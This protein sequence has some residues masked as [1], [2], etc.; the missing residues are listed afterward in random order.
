M[1]GNIR[2]LES[3]LQRNCV[4][5]FRLQYPHLIL[6]AIPNGGRRSAI[7]AAIMKGEGVMP[8]VADLF[9]MFPT[10]AH[11]GL[12]I[13]MKHRD[14]KQSEKQVRFEEQANRYG[15]GYAVARSFD[16]F[17]TVVKEFVRC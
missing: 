16:E 3:E 13:E 10:K 12:F 15:Y 1:T 5:W 8:G 9:L 6:F 4:K 17:I 7:E 11:H 2:H 14:G